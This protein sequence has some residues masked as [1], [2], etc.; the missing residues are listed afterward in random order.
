M[1][2]KQNKNHESSNFLT[3]VI[4]GGIAGA[5]A[6]LLLA[7]K[8]GRELRSDLNT[9]VSLALE[10]TDQVKDQVIRKG[11]ELREYAHDTTVK[12]SKSVQEHTKELVEKV[13]N[14][15]RNAEENAEETLEDAQRA[16]NELSEQI[17]KK[18][19]EI[20]SAK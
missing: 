2:E 10:K 19:E 16:I 9:Q 13:Q 5:V 4:I 12:L 6:A 17:D 20:K 11:N 8:S 14:F 3:G 15:T 7:P 18:L 1:E